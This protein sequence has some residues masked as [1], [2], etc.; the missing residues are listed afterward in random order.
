M[1]LILPKQNILKFLRG[2]EGLSTDMWGL[3]LGRRSEENLA[4]PFRTCPYPSPGDL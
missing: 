3:A 2:K 4:H 1:F